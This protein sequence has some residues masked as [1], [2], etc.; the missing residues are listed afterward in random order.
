M[1]R[2]RVGGTRAKLSGVLGSLVFSV[3]QSADGGYEQYIATYNDDRENPNTK[4]Q[5]LARMQIAMIERMVHI[6]T[7]LL[8][9]SFQNCSVGVES[10]NEFAK[11][12]MKSIQTYCENYWKYAFGWSFPNKGNPLECW[13]PLQIS[14]GTLKVPDVWSVTVGNWPY[15]IRTYRLQAPVGKYR[16]ADLRK[17][18]NLTR[19]GSFAFVSIWGVYQMFKT[20]AMMVKVRIADGINDTADY[21]TI[22]PAQLFAFEAKMLE[23]ATQGENKVELNPLYDSSNNV[24]SFA[25]EVYSR[26]NYGWL[27]N[28]TFLSTMLYSDYR[29]KRWLKSTARLAPPQTYTIEDEYGRAPY[30][31]FQTWDPNYSDEDYDDYFGSKK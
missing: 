20:G 19:Y 12:N 4:Y 25:P 31:A 23:A 8:R 2:S 11:V 15:Y 27:E 17:A 29:R 13:A 28:E 1:A 5:A 18:M 26:G 7:P 3:G 6:L 24:F 14:Y 10:V 30:E 9:V 16:V 22:Q 21:R